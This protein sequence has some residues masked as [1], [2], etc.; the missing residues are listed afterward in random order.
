[1]VFFFG[2]DELSELNRV[3]CCWVCFR[4]ELIYLNNIAITCAL[5]N[6][7]VLSLPV[8]SSPL[9]S[10]FGLNPKGPEAFFDA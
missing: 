1:M 9:F 7:E 2:S 4:D 6:T 10:V 8:I 3:V 5:N